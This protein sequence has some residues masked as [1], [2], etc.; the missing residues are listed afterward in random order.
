MRLETIAV[1]GAGTMGS[2]IAQKIAQEGFFVILHDRE[3]RFVEAGR[4]RI[5]STLEQGVKRKL[6]SADQA[7]EVLGRIRGT[8]D[9]TDV[10]DADLVVEAVF[11]DMEVKKTLF[12]Q[13]DRICKPETILATNTSSFLVSEIA[14]ATGRPDRVI[15][16]HYFYHPAKNR[17]L[18]VIPSESTSG[19]TIAAARLFG[20]MHGKVT[21][22]C[23]DSPGFVVNR[24]FIPWYV[25]AY[26]LLEEGV[27]DIYTID[28]VV[29]QT[30]RIG[31]GPFSLINITGTGIGYHAAAGL[32]A[33]LGDFYDGPDNIKSLSETGEKWDL[34]SEGK[35]DE[36]SRETIVDRIFGTIFYVVSALV[37][38][39]GA[40]VEDVDRGAKIALRWS[41]GPFELMN[42]VGIEKAKRLVRE[43]CKRYSLDFPGLLEEQSEDF[44]FNVVD[45]EVRDAIAFITLNRPE[46]SNA[47][48][49]ELIAQLAR[50]F[51]EA[52]SDP[53]VKT[54]VIRGAGKTFVAG[55]DIRFFLKNM[56]AKAL[57]NICAFS[58]EGTKLFRRFETSPKRTIIVL[59]GPSLGG[60]SEMVLAA[61]VVVS[62]EKGSLQFPET[63]IGIYPG[64]GG[65]Q[66]LPRMI[67]PELARYYLFTGSPISAS[68]AKKL[69]LVA[70]LVDRQDLEAAVRRFSEAEDVP[71]KYAP[72]PIPESYRAVAAAFVKENVNALLDGSFDPGDDAGLAKARKAISYK[73]PLALEKVD[74]LIDAATRLDLDEGLELDQ[75]W[76]SDIFS[77]ED[78]FEGLSKAGRA[79]P[80]FKGK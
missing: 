35:I 30:F 34:P 56:K 22:Q 65:T 78:A 54:I 61:D 73:A 41:K 27:S 80:E 28:E 3:E 75:E 6:F 51:D 77:T 79:R 71:D 33:S 64:L 21:I 32:A 72:R 5:K 52:E 9:L 17:L 8:I 62:T 25:E 4:D 16:L 48:N 10:A 19:E 74:S 70:A 20:D 13:L 11:E 59:D 60:G 18:E 42:M 26:R 7:A 67:G 12:E 63:G 69:G 43:T 58:R 68:E 24:F 50:R 39:K 55:A 40:S 29:K 53:A 36:G 57:D 49:P 44:R 76:M 15:G 23:K 45:L 38:E 2:G 46:A 37:D 47:I 66:R 14:K 31:L 1:I